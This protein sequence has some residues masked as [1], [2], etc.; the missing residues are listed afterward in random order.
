MYLYSIS[1]INLF[2]IG[3]TN[4]F[5]SLQTDYEW[6]TQL[7]STTPSYHLTAKWTSMAT[8]IKKFLIIH[9][10]AFLK[11]THKSVIP[12][13]LDIS[14]S[15]VSY[16]YQN[17]NNNVKVKISNVTTTT[18]KIPPKTLLCEIQPVIEEEIPKPIFGEN[19]DDIMNLIKISTTNLTN[20]QQQQVD[21]II[22]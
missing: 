8:L 19:F 10:C 15:F 17:N 9:V 7:K 6:W 2:C 22:E 16:K 11:N 21:N 3:T 4:A 1:W 12:Q 18:V 20:C 13:D 5:K 14:P